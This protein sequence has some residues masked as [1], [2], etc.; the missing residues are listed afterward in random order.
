MPSFGEP[1][2]GREAIRNFFVESVKDVS[3]RIMVLNS[4]RVEG[5]KTL[6]MDSG[7]YTFDG[8]NTEGSPST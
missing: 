7:E 1:V 2:Q 4:F 6:L 8:V 3:K 5:S